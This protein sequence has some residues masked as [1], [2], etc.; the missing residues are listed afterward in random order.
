M[1]Y[2]RNDKIS[3]FYL[4]LYP[5]TISALLDL[6]VSI[7]IWIPSINTACFAFASVVVV[8]REVVEAIRLNTTWSYFGP[9]LGGTSSHSYESHG[10]PP[11][12]FS[13][14]MLKNAIKTK[15]TVAWMFGYF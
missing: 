9:T 1:V 10:H 5:T 4:P 15:L 3:K 12:Q 7:F 11:G 8:A 2:F 14:K 13:L 6:Y